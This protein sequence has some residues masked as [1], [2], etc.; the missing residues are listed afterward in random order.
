M[1]AGVIGHVLHFGYGSIMD[2]EYDE[3]RIW[4][5]AA[6]N[7]LQQQSISGSQQ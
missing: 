2:M 3:L 7:I 1:A 5:D 6:L 4:T